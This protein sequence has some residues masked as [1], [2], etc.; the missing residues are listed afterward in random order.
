MQDVLIIAMV[1]SAFVFAL[2]LFSEGRGERIVRF[3]LGAIAHPEP[4]ARETK[5]IRRPQVVDASTP[6]VDPKGDTRDPRLTS[7]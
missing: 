5:Q 2:A 3:A 7:L 1:L 4:V 6:E